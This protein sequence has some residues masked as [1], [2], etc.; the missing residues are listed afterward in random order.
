M[1][2]QGAF[3]S[4]YIRKMIEEGQILGSQED[5][6]QPASMDLT[7][8]DEVYRMKGVFLPRTGE[9]ISDIL[10][11]G[12]LYKYNIENPLECG[13][14]YL[15]RV[16]EKFKLNQDIYAY[17]NN[18]SSSGR[19]NLQVRLIGDGVSQFDN[20]PC[21]YTGDLWLILSP[22]SFSV[23][24]YPG[25]RLNQIRFFNANTNLAPMHYHILNQQIGILRDKNG[26]S[27]DTN[28]PRA[29]ESDIPMSIDLDQDIVGY[30]CTPSAGKILDFR[31]FD[32]N[33]KDFFEPIYRP[34]DHG[35]VLK[36]N[37]F[38]ILSTIEY[39]RIPTEYA[40]EM[41]AYDTS[42]GEFR[43]HYAGFF[44]PGWGYGENGEGMGT[45]AVLEVLTQ[46]NE[47]Y[48]RHGQPICR[49]VFTTLSEKADLAYGSSIAGSHY[50][51][52]RGPRLGKH[53]KVEYE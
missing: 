51:N 31:K 3:P 46:D 52:Q 35:L 8:S 50:H 19:L 1:F 34:S 28:I 47:F 41:V 15:V 26:K 9:K 4:Q 18:K 27:I 44:D 36:N 24:L 10:K 5:A 23:K 38:Y 40:V 42:K 37:E 14:I 25:D 33:P 21:G 7:I 48:L 17:A 13:A 49:M 39:L 43:S 29:F 2:K 32:H 20:I 12:T 16:N 53:F 11:D 30:K 6:I 22:K 45:P